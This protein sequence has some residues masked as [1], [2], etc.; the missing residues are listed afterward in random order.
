M[1][2]AKFRRTLIAA[3]VAP[4]LAAPAA[5]LAEQHATPQAQRQQQ[6][7]P[8]LQQSDM[9]ASQVV[10]M[11]VKNPQGDTIG[12]IKDLVID[13]QS[14]KVEYAALA[15]GGFL[16]LGEDLYAYPVSRFQPGQER[17][18][19]V[20]DVTK[21]QLEQS[22][23]FDDDDWPKMREDRSFWA[24][25]DER[26][27]RDAD[28]S[29]ATGGSAQAEQ[30]PP[31]QFVRA[32]ELMDKQVTGPDNLEL[33]KIEDLVIN[34]QQGE[35]RFAVIDTEGDDRLVPASMDDLKVRSD[36]GDLAV[37]YDRDKLDLSKAFDKDQWPEELRAQPRARQAR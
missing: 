31:R 34:L 10:G 33:G 7:A 16:G 29:A 1:L 23:G 28:R 19:L 2:P 4:A 5:V 27:G 15:H 36:G 13:T 3:L 9:R 25:V 22:A 30:Q 32:S 14:G 24:N 20:L 8:Q 18:Q 11:D 6:S 26:F 17:D 35:I 21:E 12:K 37:Q